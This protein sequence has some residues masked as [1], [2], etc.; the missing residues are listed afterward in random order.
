MKSTNLKTLL[1]GASL[2]ILLSTAFSAPA[3]AAAANRAA[4]AADFFSTVSQVKPT[5]V[6]LKAAAAAAAAA[7]GGASDSE[8]ESDD[9]SSGPG[10]FDAVAASGGN[11]QKAGAFADLLAAYKTAQKAVEKAAEADKDAVTLIK[12]HSTAKREAE[13]RAK[14]LLEEKAQVVSQLAQLTDLM[15]E[16]ARLA[17]EEKQKLVDAQALVAAEANAKGIE[18]EA[19]GRE[20]Q[21]AADQARDLETLLTAEKAKSL[22]LESHL[23]L[24]L[25]WE[26]TLMSSKP[27][28]RLCLRKSARCSRKSS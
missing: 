6:D 25:L 10:N 19:K 8:D 17:T 3:T 4:L 2:A 5:D 24:Q 15:A 27:Q 14:A 7:T 21:A 26:L 20:A 11:L 18:A 9:E 22:T 12:K 1:G 13:V 23:L 16:Q 28:K